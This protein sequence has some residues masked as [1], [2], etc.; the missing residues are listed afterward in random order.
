MEP[1]LFAP[2]SQSFDTNGLGKL[3]RTVKAE[4]HKTLDY[5]YDLNLTLLD[6]DPLASSIIIES[7]IAVQADK[8]GRRQGFTVEE[9]TRNLDG[10]IDVYANHVAMHELKTYTNGLLQVSGENVSR[11]AALAQLNA[12]SI[13]SPYL[14][15]PFHF[16][17]Y[18]E[19]TTKS[20][21]YVPTPVTYAEAING[22]IETWAG[23]P[24]SLTALYGGEWDFDN[25]EIGW[26][27]RLGNSGTNAGGATPIKVV[28][29]KNMTAFKLADEY[30]EENAPTCCIG[31]WWNGRGDSIALLSAPQYSMYDPVH[32]SQ[33]YAT[34]AKH[35][36]TALVDFS[37]EFDE[38]VTPTTAQLN[39]LALK[40]IAGKGLSHINMEVSFDTFRNDDFGIGDSVRV[41]ND[42]YGID[43]ERRIIGY[44]F[45]PLAEVYT[46][47]EIGDPKTTINEAIAGTV[48]T[49]G[50]GSGGGGITS[51]DARNV[52]F[53]PAMAGLT[54]T[55]V[56]NAL[57]EVATGTI[58]QQSGQGWNTTL[59][60]PTVNNP[61]N[62]WKLEDESWSATMRRSG[63]SGTYALSIVTNRGGSNTFN[64]LINSS[65]VRQWVYPSEMTA[66]LTHKA[67]KWSEMGNA[68]TS[69]L[70][71][72][73][74]SGTWLLVT[75]HNSTTNLNTVWIV[76][77]VANRAF[78]VGG[79]T[80][81]VTVTMSDSL[82]TVKTTSGTAN[83]YVSEI[84]NY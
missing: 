58:K 78:Q 38:G 62:V 48:H 13:Y 15:C 6:D 40:W 20:F 22:D 35:T 60:T 45:D 37:D 23:Q 82:V 65:G 47:V 71:F 24:A 41:I 55:D 34:G 69:G 59:N 16:T 29:G 56:Q 53:D 1:R 39:A 17:L 51:I 80:G 81:N 79:Q 32:G 84:G 43:T 9:I 21:Y 83:C 52:T 70:Q 2:G 76:R 18:G 44:K 73:L 46:S 31:Y 30:D 3:T 14:P 5:K 7:I 72:G 50:S 77:A 64:S 68:G 4:V 8:N 27:D 10:T 75:G 26:Y 42:Q 19:N 61:T 33:A 63:A 66:A 57:T 67:D 11:Q 25:F 74:T 54:S 28:P 36:R 12:G 49:S